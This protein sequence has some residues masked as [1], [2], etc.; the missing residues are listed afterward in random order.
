MMAGEVCK[1]GKTHTPKRISKFAIFIFLTL[2][3]PDGA[4][5][6]MDLEEACRAC[7]TAIFAGQAHE[8]LEGKT[9]PVQRSSAGK[10]RYVD[11]DVGGELLQIME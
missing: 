2:K 8:T 6:P 4:M 7:A 9:L 11:V 5:S 10:L 3:Y 1:T